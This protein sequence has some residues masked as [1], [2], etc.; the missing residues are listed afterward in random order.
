MSKICRNCK[1]DLPVLCYKP[2][3]NS[4]DGLFPMCSACVHLLRV[5]Q[6]ENYFRYFPTRRNVGLSD[7]VR[8]SCYDSVWR[9]KIHG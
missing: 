8:N 2:S 7:F 6:L 3:E 5:N 1:R 9:G 4:D